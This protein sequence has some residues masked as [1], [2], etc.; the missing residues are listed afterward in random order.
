MRPSDQAFA[1]AV[2][3]AIE[4]WEA[5]DGPLERLGNPSARDCFI[6]QLVDSDRRRR[7]VEHFRDRA[8]VTGR[9]AD[10]SSGVFNPFAAAVWHGRTGDLD[11]ALWLAFLA[12]HFGRHPKARWRYMERVYGKLNSGR[13]DWLT[14]AADTVGFRAWLVANVEAIKGVGPHGFGNHR[15]R[16]SL[17]DSGTGKAIESYV[18]WI[19]PKRGH[20]A[21]FSVMT[22]LGAQTPAEEFESL[23]ESMRAVCR[24]GRL[25]RFDY[26]TTAS[27][28]GLT[29]AVAS[30]PYL[31]ESTGPLTGAR[32]LFGERTPKQ[33]EEIAVEFGNT[34]GIPFAVLE[35]ALCN[36]QKSPDAFIRFRE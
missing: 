33:L 13:W 27:R 24:F 29:T 20:T 25:A 6:R 31:P 1:T 9:Q 23:Y 5:T 26:L 11:E 12:V 10:P 35:D 3:A 4:G 19:D 30:R 16:E 15:K 32:L 22:G 28:L 34:T 21:A 2:S 17:S 7:Y 18:T 14:V 8:R 36:W